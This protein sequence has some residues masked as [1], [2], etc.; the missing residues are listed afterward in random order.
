M[1]G[2]GYILWA[3][4]FHCVS[5]VGLAVPVTKIKQQLDNEI[6]AAG[7]SLSSIGCWVEHKQQKI[8]SLNGEEKFMPASVTKILPAAATLSR[9]TS[10][11]Q[12]ET[13]LYADGEVADGVLRG[14]IYLAGGGDPTFTSE[15]MWVMVNDLVREEIRRVDGDLIV[16]DRRFDD[17]RFDPGRDEDAEDRDKSYTA[18]V[19]AMSFNWNSVH[20]A[21]RPGAEVGQPV[22]VFVNP[23]ND[24]IEVL[25]EAS[26][27]RGGGSNLEIIRMGLRFAENGEARD[28]IKV[29]GSLGFQASEAGAYRNITR[30]DLWSA[31]NLKSFMAQ[32]GMSVSGIVRSGERPPSARLLVK[33]AGKTVSHAVSDMMKFSNNY[34]AEML[35]KNLAF[36][37]N[38]RSRA[39]MDEGLEVLR[40]FLDGYGILRKN[41]VLS[42]PSG[43]S[44]KNLFRPKDLHDLVAKLRLKMLNFP[45]YL[46]A[47]A[48]AGTDGTL[49]GRMR[50]TAAEGRIRAKTGTISGVVTLVGYAMR[51]DGEVITFAFMYNGGASTAAARGLFD[52][53][54]AALFL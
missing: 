42:S 31:A 7:L 18:P 37:K 50:N 24:Y 46:S 23:D 47:Q 21:V 4:V 15:N 45:E 11:H 32:R 1:L 51:P 6:R 5:S 14:N 54:A 53:M 20:I 8:F 3:I 41:Y 44:R 2:R 19:G 26:T 35:T 9:L 13:A 39:S 12:F 16:D 22:K 10:S 33:T 40:E 30:P 17:V 28:T 43:L 36:E 34:M 29:R 48:V 49:S 25:N 27:V 38:R 52:K